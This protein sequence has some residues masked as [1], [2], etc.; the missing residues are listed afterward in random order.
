M[1]RL[2]RLQ[3]LLI[4]KHLA[5]YFVTKPE[6]IFYLTGFTGDDSGVLVTQ[7]DAVLITDSRYIAQAH[8]QLHDDIVILQEQDGILVA[9]AKL[10]E[11]RKFTSLGF[12]GTQL[13]YQDFQFLKKALPNQKFQSRNGLVEQLRQVKD[14]DELANIKISCQIADQCFE[15]ILNFIQPGMTELS[16][17][18]EMEYD[19]RKRGASGVSFETIVASGYRS[20]W[21]HGSA[22]EKVIQNHELI[23]LDFGCFYNHYA[24]DI[25]RTVAL[26]TVDPELAHIYDVVLKANQRVLSVVKPGI[27]GQAMHDA[28]HEVIDGAGYGPNFGHGTGHSIGLEIHEGPGAFGA[29]KTQKQVIANVETDEPGI[30]LEGKGGVRIEDDFVVTAT[31]YELLTHAPKNHLIQL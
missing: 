25:T 21:P 5:N 9:L 3:T 19:M 6:N 14:A 12:D 8:Q 2:Q 17:A 4:E 23:T 18:N 28:A 31:G 30:Y 24:S 20:A 15:H 26:G 7:D 22:S 11:T 10:L 1:T 27:S 16:V 29:Y 13:N